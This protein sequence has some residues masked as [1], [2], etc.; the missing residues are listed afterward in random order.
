MASCRTRLFLVLVAV[1]FLVVLGWYHSAYQ[2]SGSRFAA[3]GRDDAP[4]AFLRDPS[5]IFTLCVIALAR[6]DVLR[7]GSQGHAGAAA[8]GQ[9]SPLYGPSG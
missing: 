1:P 4:F 2:F 5:F 9:S 3:A 6:P 8:T 7:P